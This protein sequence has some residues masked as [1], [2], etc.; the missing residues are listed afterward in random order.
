MTLTTEEHLAVPYVMVM[1][2]VETPT[3]DWLRQASYPELPGCSAQ[4]ATPLEAI[5]RLEELRVRYILERLESG[6]PVPV[7]RPPLRYG[8]EGLSFE[9]LGF[10]KWLKDN[11]RISD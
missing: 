4:A 3:G 5:D 10:A 9:R 11:R 2:S 1:E 6:R 8:S 7:P